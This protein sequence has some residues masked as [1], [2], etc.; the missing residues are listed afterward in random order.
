[1]SLVELPI[2]GYLDRFSHRPGESFAAYIGMRAAG[3]YEARLVRIVSGDPNPAG[4]KLRFEDLSHVFA[5]RFSG[6][7]QE[8]RLGSYARIEPGPERDPG[9]PFT[10][11]ALVQL[12]AELRPDS[13]AK[14]IL[15]LEGEDGAL[16]LSVGPRGAEAR[17]AGIEVD[18]SA[19]RL[20]VETPMRP[21]RWYR[22]WLSIDPATERVLLGQQGFGEAAPVLARSQREGVAFATKSC[23]LIAAQSKKGPTD[24]FTGKIEDPAI[25]G[26][27]VEGFRH[28]AASLDALGAELIAGWDFSQGIDTQEVTDIG[29]QACHG[30]LV[31]L[32]T[33]GVVGARWSGSEMCWR[34]APR[35]YGAIHFH[36]DDL[37][38]CG[39]EP[40]FSWTVPAALRSGAY[41]FHLTC[42]AGEDWLPFYVLPP[43]D[44][45]FAPIAFLASTFTYQAYANHA[46]GNADEAYHRRVAEWGAYPN[47]P[48]QHPIYGTSTYNRH[49][50]GAGIAFSSRR[51][52]ILT[53]RPGFLTFNDAR[54]SGLRHYP[55]DTHILSWLE[56][57]GF[58]FD[59]ITDEDLDDEGE[60]LIAPYRM[61]LTGSHPEYHTLRTLDALQNYTGAGGKLAYLGGNGFY[62]RIARTQ[63]MPHVIE[64]RRAE[65]GIRAWAADPGEY[66]HA[67]DGEFGGLWRRNR[68]PPQMLAGVGFSGQGLFEGTHYRRLPASRDPAHAWIFEGIEEEIIGDYG[69]SGGGAAGFEMDR[70]DRALG[71]PENAVILARSEDPPA[72]FVTVP[73]EL[74]SHLHTVSGEPPNELKRAEIVYFDTPSCGAVFSVGSITFCGS[75]WRNGFEG[76]VSRLLENVVRRFSAAK[77]DAKEA[78]ELG[79]TGAP[80]HHD[81]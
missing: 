72:S 62:W 31:N 74:L 77:P 58:S 29:P 71:T 10:L 4:P 12:R 68:R 5:E 27:Y 54:G 37:A 63:A 28:P 51:R 41:A 39:W 14:A 53:M 79:R 55:A 36:D 7:H 61:V 73:E 76:P 1:M 48:D 60:G 17:L 80:A 11:T 13:D 23:V 46:R 8:I 50:D 49:A 26:A 35:D 15:A 78:S 65:G 81:A 21:L 69:L 34:H 38:D 16:A 52:P 3:P 45:P 59:I 9:L 30:H 2:T 57:K 56:E 6:R 75:L 22:V 25:L 64:I 47:N 44:G 24:H 66:Y 19:M 40:D 20:C 18:A 67:L 70:A 43:R 42:D 33:R 32:P